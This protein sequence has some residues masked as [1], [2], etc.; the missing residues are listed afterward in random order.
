MKLAGI[1]F[2]LGLLI[3]LGILIQ[4]ALNGSLGADPAKELNH[5]LGHWALYFLLLNLGIG[6][7]IWVVVQF[8]M[9]MPVFIRFLNQQRRWLG[10]VGFFYATLHLLCY[11]LMEA[12][13][14]KALQQLIEKQYLLIGFIAFCILLVLAVTSNNWTIKKLGQ[15]KW[16]KIHRAVYLAFLLLLFHIFQIEKADLKW[17]AQITFPIL[18]FLIVRGA[19]WFKNKSGESK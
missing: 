9:Q 19:F 6:C 17:F 1:V 5:Q 18:F 15:K 16:K 11:G 12:F 8:K 7:L 13:E 14:W 3:P 2:K 4:R 10:N